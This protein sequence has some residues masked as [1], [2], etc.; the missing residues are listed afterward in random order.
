[1]L[2]F[3]AGFAAGVAVAVVSIGGYA[4]WAWRAEAVKRT[5]WRK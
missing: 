4:V 3:G 1:M 2:G 5:G